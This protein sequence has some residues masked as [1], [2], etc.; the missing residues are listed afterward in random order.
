[1]RR[2][3]PSGA[4][5]IGAFLQSEPDKM[6]CSVSAS[7]PDK[8]SGQGLFL[9]LKKGSLPADAASRI[10]PDRA[11]ILPIPLSD[12][13][14]TVTPSSDRFRNVLEYQGKISQSTSRSGLS[15]FRDPARQS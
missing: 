3:K 8:M 14:R 9:N 10:G 1:M 4:C 2:V 11:A 7:I 5:S 6:S 15:P 12:A 13:T